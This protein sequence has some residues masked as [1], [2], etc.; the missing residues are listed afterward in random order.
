[1]TKQECK[2]IEF[3]LYNYNRINLL[4]K[5]LYNYNRINLL[6]KE[7][8]MQIIDSINVSNKSWIKSLKGIGNTTEDQ[9]IKLIEDNLIKEY[10]QWQVFI[11]KIL[12]FLY[13]YKPL[14]YKYLKLKYLLEKDNKEIMRVLKINFEQLKILRIKLLTFIYKNGNKDKFELNMEE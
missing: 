13:E 3:Y 5:D 10:K 12:A 9:V 6:I 1:M 11:K 2:K 14:Y 8:E 7:R 4:I